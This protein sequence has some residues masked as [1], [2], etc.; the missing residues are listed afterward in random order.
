[1]HLRED[2]ELALY[3]S[4]VRALVFNTALLA[5]KTTRATQGVQVMT[6][7][8]KYRLERVQTLAESSITNL[9]RYR[10]RSIPAAGAIL[11]EEDAEERQMQL[12]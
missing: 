7:K 11:K 5:P 2:K 9:G 3:T 6:I 1:M 12:L 4:E 8:P 10:G